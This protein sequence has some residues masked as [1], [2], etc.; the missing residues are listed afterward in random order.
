MHLET[1][2]TADDLAPVELQPQE[3]SHAVFVGLHAE[4]VGLHDVG[5]GSCCVCPLSVFMPEALFFV[6]NRHPVVQYSLLRCPS[7]QNESAR[8]TWRSVVHIRPSGALGD[9]R[10]T[11]EAHNLNQG[12][13]QLPKARRYICRRCT[14]KRQ[15]ENARCALEIASAPQ[16]HRCTCRSAGAAAATYTVSTRLNHLS[17]QSLTC[18]RFWQVKTRLS[19]PTPLLRREETQ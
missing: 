12:A 10:C 6:L 16:R 13:P 17:K 7:A 2:Q 9:A 4:G 11:W 18:D 5:T 19:H 15:H 14:W 3:R 1:T 8:C